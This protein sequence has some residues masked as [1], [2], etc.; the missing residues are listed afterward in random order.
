MNAP[1]RYVIVRVSDG[2]I[3]RT[4]VCD[5]DQAELQYQ[6]GEALIQHDL[7]DATTHYFTA[8]G[9][10]EYP[11]TVALA[12]SQRP[13]HPA[14]WSNEALSWV[15]G[16]SIAEVRAARLERIKLEREA[17]FY[18]PITVDGVTVDADRDSVANIM[19]AIMEMQLT[20]TETRRW[21]LHDNT[22][23]D[24]TLAQLVAIGSAIAERKEVLQN[25]SQDIRQ[26]IE[27]AQTSADVAAVTW[28]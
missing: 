25:Q 8:G 11:P 24:L 26:L 9:I 2:E 20:G 13:Q 27:A 14:E 12:K 7:A 23:M 10:A 15:D 21:T 18:A 19:G 3:V 5:S 6:S 1:A 17:R 22:R 4:V 28:P 16:R